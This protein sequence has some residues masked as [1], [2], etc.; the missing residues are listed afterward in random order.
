MVWG[1]R[2]KLLRVTAVAALTV[3]IAGCTHVVAGQSSLEM[4]PAGEPID[5][6]ECE[7]RENYDVPPEAECGW[8]G[9]PVDWDNPD[10][11]T[12]ELALLRIPATGDKIGSLVINPGGPGFGGNDLALGLVEVLPTEVRERFDLVG[13][14]P[15]GT[16]DSRPAVRCNTDQEDDDIRAEPPLEQTPD[17]VDHLN[18]ETKAFVQRCLDKMGEEFLANLGTV[19]VAK[20]L[21]A[22]REALGDEKLTYLGYS[23]GTFIGSTYAELFPENVGRLILDG[24]VDPNEDPVESSVAQAAAFQGT[25]NEY[26][27][28]CAK[29]ADCPLGQDPTKAVDVYRSLVETLVDEPATTDDPRGLSYGDAIVGTTMALYSPT[30]WQYLTDGLDEVSRDRGDTLLWLSDLYY[31][32]DQDGHYTSSADANIAINC[33]DSPPITD[34]DT[35]LEMDRRIR[36]VAPWESYGTYTGHTSMPA[37]AYWPVPPTSEPHEVSV[38]NL[39]PTLV[40]STTGDPATPYQAGVEL[41]KQLGGGLLT[42][43]GNQHTVVFNGEECVDSIATDYLINGTLPPEGTRC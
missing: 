21:D 29:D 5:W 20:D 37:C 31:E 35:L 4:V 7:P 13:F 10:G 33:V 14:D 38:E 40:V 24:A 42:Y 36:E 19:S 17:N 32:R 15:R 2:H 25:F 1:A 8:L 30:Y 28:D 23:Y 34:M 27:A 26:A 16:A 6:Q 39:A 11:D 9:V 41:A 18:D 3:G 22:I 12:I 43:E